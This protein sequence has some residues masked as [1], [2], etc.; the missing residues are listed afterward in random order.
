[1]NNS[2]KDSSTI[3]L[4]YYRDDVEF[5]SVTKPTDGPMSHSIGQPSWGPIAAGLHPVLQGSLTPGISTAKTDLL[6]TC[7]LLSRGNHKHLW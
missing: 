2:P 6:I 1:M 5:N 3:W 4:I 7:H